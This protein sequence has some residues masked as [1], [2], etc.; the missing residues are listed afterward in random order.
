ME[1]FLVTGGARSGKSRFCLYE[2]KRAGKRRIFIA[3]AVAGDEE[4]ARRIAAHK[5][6][7]G[8]GW[9]TIEEPVELASAVD[10]ALGEADVVLVDCLTLW[11]SNLCTD[12]QGPDS[13]YIEGKIAELIS[14]LTKVKGLYSDKTLFMVTNE[15]GSG[16]VP[17]TPLGRFFRDMAGFLNQQVAAVADNVVLMIAGLPVYAKQKGQPVFGRRTHS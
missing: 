1:I 8:E 9:L 2:A 15:L 12:G 13:N 16:I 10:R 3:T 4:M 11:L 17:A 6:E 7:R 14:L 5:E